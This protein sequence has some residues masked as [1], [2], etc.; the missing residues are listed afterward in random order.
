MSYGIL[1]LS[2]LH[3][4]ADDNANEYANIVGSIVA[5][6]DPEV[7]AVL[8]TGDLVDNAAM[9]EF[10]AWAQITDVLIAAGF[11]VMAV[12]GNHDVFTTRGVDVGFKGTREGWRAHVLPRIGGETLA[13]GV[14]EWRWGGRQILGTD[15]Q[16]ASSQDDDIGAARGRLGNSQLGEIII[17]LETGG[18]VAG[19]HRLLW[20]D[21]LH[22]L[23]DA[24]QFLR[25][26][27]PRAG[28]YLCGH[29]HA[30]VASQRGDLRIVAA[31]RSTQRHQGRL[32]YRVFDVEDYEHRWHIV[33][34]S[35]EKP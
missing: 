12:P 26:L 17:C 21:V 3:I 23:D 34:E 35:S 31:P 7:D 9:R 14:R 32:R 29:Q 5:N 4:G 16:L 18:I 25:I 27:E 24:N 2:D 13:H 33:D 11:K 8:I 15:T 20:R 30:D 1:H 22:A 6:H 10:E 19:H 28:L